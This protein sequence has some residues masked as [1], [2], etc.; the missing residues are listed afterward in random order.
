[1]TAAVNDHPQGFLLAFGQLDEFQ[2]SIPDRFS[3][4]R[5]IF[6]QTENI[7]N[8]S[9]I[10]AW[11]INL[12][13]EMRHD[14]K[15]ICLE[16]FIGNGNVFDHQPAQAEILDGEFITITRNN[17]SRGMRIYVV[18]PVFSSFCCHNL[19]SGKR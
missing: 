17:H 5:S 3:P 16:G 18:P 10:D 12:R 8:R 13:M 11:E 14:I 2:A 7:I 6:R 4:E 15:Q 19:T 9:A 1:M